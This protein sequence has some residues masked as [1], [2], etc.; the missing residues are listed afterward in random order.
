MTILLY[1]FHLQNGIFQ[2]S[3]FNPCMPFSPTY[4]SLFYLG[5]EHWNAV[6]YNLCAIISLRQTPIL[7]GDTAQSNML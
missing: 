7:T 3:V 1:Y 2:Q 6:L 5:Q 4:F